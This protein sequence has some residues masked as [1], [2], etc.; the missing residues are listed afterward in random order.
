MHKDN[1]ENIFIQVMGS[2]TF[3]ILPPL[4]APCVNEQHLISATYVDK[5]SK[6]E[7]NSAEWLLVPQID[8]PRSTIPFPTWDPEFPSRRASM[9]SAMARP[10]NVKLGEGDMLYLPALWYHKVSQECNSEGL[11][12]SVNYWYAK[13]TTATLSNR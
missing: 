7:D 3:T 4:E 13:S 9:F 11:C 2:K 12:S 10:M 6:L 5:G 1:Y 8:K